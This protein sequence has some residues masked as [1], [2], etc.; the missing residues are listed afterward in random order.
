[1]AFTFVFLS[2]DSGKAH[3]LHLVVVPYGS[4]S[5]WS[6]PL[7]L[8]FMLLICRAKSH[9]LDWSLCFLTVLFNFEECLR[10]GISRV[11][12]VGGGGVVALKVEEGTRAAGVV[13]PVLGEEVMSGESFQIFS[14]HLL[15]FPEEVILCLH[16]MYPGGYFY[17]SM[18]CVCVCVNICMYV[19]V[20][21]YICMYINVIVILVAKSCPNL[22]TTLW[23]VAHQA[24]LSMGFPRQECWGGLL[25]PLPGDLS[26]AGIKPVSPA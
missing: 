16:S 2:E 23:T 12:G 4:L 24:P 18:K 7:F 20:C 26:D 1:M 19:Y 9:F 25:F 22:V 6:R 15:L 3:M 13:V 17:V 5:L 21:V 11:V 10:C 8:F 14:G